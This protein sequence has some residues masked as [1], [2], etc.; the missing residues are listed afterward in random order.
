MTLVHYLRPTTTWEHDQGKYL[1]TDVCASTSVTCSS[2]TCPIWCFRGC[3]LNA[4]LETWSVLFSFAVEKL[5]NKT[6]LFLLK[7]FKNLQI[8]TFRLKCFLVF[9]HIF[10]EALTI[11]ITLHDTVAV[12]GVRQNAM[13]ACKLTLQKKKKN[14][15]SPEQTTL[16]FLTLI[17]TLT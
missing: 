8:I 5:Q 14:S 2:C 9:S 7:P 6:I 1:I 16:K 17:S 11:R 4:S 13:Y 3:V 10:L 15:G 12:R